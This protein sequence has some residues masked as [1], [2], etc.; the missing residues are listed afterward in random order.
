MVQWHEVA[1]VGICGGLLALER[2]AFLQAMFS[3][4][5]VSATVIGWMLGDVTSGLYVGLPLELFFLGSASLGAALP[6]ND[7]L[8]ATGTAAAAATMAISS[9]GG[10]TPALWA[11]SL[12]LFL[13]LGKLGRVFDRLLEQHTT[14]LARRAVT[15]AEAG[16][17]DAAMRSNLRGMWLHFALFGATTASCALIGMG[18]GAGFHRLPLWLVR[19]LAWAYPAVAVVSAAVAVRGS[20]ARRA[21]LMGLLGALSV[22]LV[23][24]GQGL[25]RGR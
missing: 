6:E 9:G 11:L 19:G 1:L 3:R 4:P 5:L 10:G 24:T 23:A 15:L 14:G 18:L 20:H 21:W 12:M 16:A 22:L 25:W 7:T 13:G 17:L 8:T 2:R